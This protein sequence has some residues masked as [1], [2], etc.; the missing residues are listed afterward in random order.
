MPRGRPKRLQ[1]PNLGTD[2]SV[3]PSK[4]VEVSDQPSV[5]ATTFVSSKFIER[6][7][8]LDES[9][10]RKRSAGKNII[11]DSRVKPSN[12]F[13]RF[14]AEAIKIGY[15]PN[16]AAEYAI[17]RMESRRDTIAGNWGKIDWSSVK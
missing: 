16:V 11:D 4:S 12:R 13:Y 8:G 3:V 2:K 15:D 6:L 7:N 10:K 17:R 9:F 1:S 5:K 14:V